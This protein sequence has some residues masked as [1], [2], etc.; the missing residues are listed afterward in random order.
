MYKEIPKRESSVKLRSWLETNSLKFLYEEN[1]IHG[2][3]VRNRRWMDP[4]AIVCRIKEKALYSGMQL[5]RP[6][7]K[8][9]YHQST[10]MNDA[11]RV[12]F[13]WSWAVVVTWRVDSP[14]NRRV[15]NQ[16]KTLDSQPSQKSLDEDDP[17]Q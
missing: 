13:S 4:L 8:M 1:N 3:T 10:W 17:S 12:L 2:S 6:F 9:K 16:S 14:A 7:S 5:L 15:D 11:N